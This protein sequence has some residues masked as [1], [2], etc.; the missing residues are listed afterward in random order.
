[1]NCPLL[2]QEGDMPTTICLQVNYPFNTNTFGTLYA[3]DGTAEVGSDY[4]K[5]SHTIVFS[6]GE[7]QVC[8]SIHIADD[9]ECEVTESFTVRLADSPDFFPGQPSCS[10]NIEDNDSEFMYEI[11]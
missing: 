3:I 9:D 8:V 2:A 11:G 1:M 4:S 7:S 10:V 6:P 5:S